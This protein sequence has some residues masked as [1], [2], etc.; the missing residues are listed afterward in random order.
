MC[1]TI[2]SS[3]QKLVLHLG[4]KVWLERESEHTRAYTR[5]KK[6]VEGEEEEEGL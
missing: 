4:S 1:R 2:V 5:M 6:E 3:G